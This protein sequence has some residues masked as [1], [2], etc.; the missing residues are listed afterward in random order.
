MRR[1]MLG[2][3]VAVAA[4]SPLH[5]QQETVIR[6]FNQAGPFAVSQPFA[7]DT[8]DVN[9]KPFAAKTILD[10][11][12]LS[13]PAT[14]RFSGQ[15]LPSLDKSRSVGLLTFYVNNNDYL[16]GKIEVKG[17]KNYKLF[18]DGT[19]ATSDLSLAPEHHTFAIAYLAEPRDTDSIQVRIDANK[20]VA[21]TL[22]KHHPYMSHDLFDGKRV[23]GIAPP[24]Y[25]QFVRL[26]Y[27]TTERGGN[28]RWEYELREVKTQRLLSRPLH[29]PKW[30]PATSAYLE[31][32][33][34]EGK[35]TLYK[36][37]PR[38]GERTLFAASI[39]EGDYTVSPTEDY[40][41]ITMKEEGPKEDPGVFEV[42]EMD[43]RQPGFRTRT[44]L[45]KYDISTGI[46]Q[47]ITFGHRNTYLED[48]SA[49]GRQLLIGTF[50][51]RLSQR[52]TEVGDCFI[53]D[54]QTL[55]ADTLFTC[56]GFI[57]GGSFSP[58][59]KKILFMGTPEAF[60]RIGCQLRHAQ[61]DGER[62]LPL[63]HRHEEG[64]SA[65]Q[66]LRPFHLEC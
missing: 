44:Y 64:Q 24:A 56:K 50:Y 3:L 23:R 53:M 9:G 34:V 60:D 13:L 19:E 37:D 22:D 1:A 57:G 2:V 8:V 4:Q 30:L 14:G 55:Q 35:R 25:G 32:E 10:G 42:L 15:V 39:P 18:I 20:A 28:A 66:G 54:A 52:P 27:Q 45:S 41:I 31:E 48:I 7:S 29:N 61:H 63:R 5:A 16:K 33:Q 58:D 11:I 17:P 46:T 65:H 43:D 6:E 12:S 47:R 38:S 21:Y 51:T 49:D 36:V 26:S 40:L 59:G 62:T